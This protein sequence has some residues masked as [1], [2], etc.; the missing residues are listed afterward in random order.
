MLKRFSA[1]LLALSWALTLTACGQLSGTA[2]LPSQ[3]DPAPSA[4]LTESPGPAPSAQ[5][6]QGPET[7][8]PASQAPESAPPAQSHEP[9][10]PAGYDEGR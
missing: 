3:P 9:E 7:A 4:A 8:A 6:D 5:T 2:P 10:A 1:L